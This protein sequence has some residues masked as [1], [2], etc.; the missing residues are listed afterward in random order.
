MTSFALLAFITLSMLFQAACANHMTLTAQQSTRA[1]NSVFLTPTKEKTIFI[2]VRN[3]SDQPSA[4][5]SELPAAI[6]AKGY[7]LTEDPDQAHFILQVT[8]VFAAK[9]K[10]GATLDTL[11]SGGFGAAIGGAAGT[12]LALTRGGLG[13]IP[14]GT[15]IGAGVGL[16]AS[17]LTEDTQFTLVADAQITERTKGAVEQTITTQSKPGGGLPD[18][19]GPIIGLF[20]AGQSVAAPQA[21]Q[22]H[23]SIQETRRG[24]ERIHT[25]RYATLSQE[26][27]PDDARTIQ[28]LKGRLIASIS[29]LF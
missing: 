3:T 17:K 15:L 7:T 24:N 20:G 21:G 13:F 11:V 8:T 19:N 23:Q 18:Q 16:A 6:A 27:W 4:V 25:V 29:G 28:D 1:S 14:G 2:E 10:P 12:T 9:A 26:M 5:L 22:A